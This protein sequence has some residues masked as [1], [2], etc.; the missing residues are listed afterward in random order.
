MAT[1]KFKIK[2]FNCEACI[3]LSKSMIGEI[4]GVKEVRIKD[5]GGET[6]VEADREIPLSE[7]QKALE[8]TNY[9][10]VRE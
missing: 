6:E 9:E 8:G 10:V 7:I 2:N 4:E 5:L 1:I 3:E